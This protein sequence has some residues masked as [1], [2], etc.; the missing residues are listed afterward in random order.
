MLLADIQQVFAGTWPA[1]RWGVTLTRWAD[2]FRDLVELLCEMKDRPWPEAQRGKP[3]SERW[4]A[5]T[6]SF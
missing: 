6:W 2:I 3:I 4:L 5:R 1:T